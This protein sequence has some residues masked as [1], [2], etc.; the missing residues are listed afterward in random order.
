MSEMQ[1]IAVAINKGGAGKTMVAK[2]LSTAAAHSGLNVLVLDM[3]TQQNATQWGRRRKEINPLPVVRFSTENDLPDELS[4]AEQAG[5]D[6]VIIDTPPGRSSETPAAVE[7]ADLIVVPFAPEVDH[8]EG[9]PRI[10]RLARTTG[11]PAVGV[12]NLAEP[13]SHWEET[14]AR[15]VL[16]GIGLALA[17][18]VLHR[19]K[20]HKDASL[21]GMT[22]QELDANSRAAA[23]IAN[24]WKFIYSELQLCTIATM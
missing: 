5:C 16:A 1:I 18:A 17:P 13:N 3:D 22:A 21:K 11:K 14:T 7:A 24:L 20:V 19:F 2:C 8:Y 15:G 9:I 10:V 23:E 4:R 6:L 12:L